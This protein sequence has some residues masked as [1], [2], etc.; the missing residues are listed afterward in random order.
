[1]SRNTIYIYFPQVACGAYHSLA[2]VRSLPPKNSNT[3]NP[4]EKRERGQSPHYSVAE[5]EEL[6]AVD[7]GH[8]C[9]LGVELTEVMTG[10]VNVRLRGPRFFSTGWCQSLVCI[11]RLL[12]RE[13]VP[14]ESSNLGE[15]QLAAARA[16]QQAHVQFP[17]M[18]T[19][20]ST[21]LHNLW[22]SCLCLGVNVF[23]LLTFFLHL[24]FLSTFPPGR[25]FQLAP[26]LSPMGT[27]TLWLRQM[28]APSPTHCQAGHPIRTL[29]SLMK[30]S[31]RT[32][33]RNFLFIHWRCTTPQG[34][35]IP[36]HWAVTLQVG[37]Q[38]VFLLS[39]FL[40]LFIR[41]FT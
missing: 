39:F 29:L 41:S 14:D 31:F 23:F 26:S 40:S 9:P 22:I 33:S 30:Q 11:P 35:A 10:E 13:V 20:N 25:I 3:H 21:V 32:S 24:S 7:G 12:R 19:L 18:A 27:L 37:N 16:L 5:R 28:A 6:F 17:K 8:Y 38:A 36:T 1:M 2:L 4:S 15:G 34:P